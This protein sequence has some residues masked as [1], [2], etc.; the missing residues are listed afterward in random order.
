MTITD[1][2]GR[3]SRVRQPVPELGRWGGVPRWFALAAGGI[4][5]VHRLLSLLGFRR[6]RIVALSGQSQP[7]VSSIIHGRQV[8]AYGVLSCVADGVGVPR[9][10]RG[11]SGCAGYGRR[12]A[13]AVGAWGSGW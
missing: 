7:G 5:T 13:A 3:R 10:Y 4:T 8:V 2:A 6:Q 12:G 11:V 1:T 9:G